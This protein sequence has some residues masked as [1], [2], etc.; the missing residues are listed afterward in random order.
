ML[1]GRTPFGGRNDRRDRQ[2]ALSRTAADAA[3]LAPD[4]SPQTAFVLER[5]MSVD[6]TLR[7]DSAR[8]FADELRTGLNTRVILSPRVILSEAKDRSRARR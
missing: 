8:E 4:V 5:A 2:A 3:D 7:P 1:S 6:P